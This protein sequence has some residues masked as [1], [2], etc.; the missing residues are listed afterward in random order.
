MIGV[1]VNVKLK[2]LI[3]S[4]IVSGVVNYKPFLEII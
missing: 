1:N 3:L 2:K 4:C